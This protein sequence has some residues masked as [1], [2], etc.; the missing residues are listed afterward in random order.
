M[1]KQIEETSK[2]EPECTLYTRIGASAVDEE[3]HRT[4]E[5]AAR[6]W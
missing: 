2:R 3:M 5:A 4:A 6:Q 1:D